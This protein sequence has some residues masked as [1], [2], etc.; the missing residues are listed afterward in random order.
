MPLK[1]SDEEKL[2]FEKNLTQ[3]NYNPKKYQSAVQTIKVDGKI[4]IK[5]EKI[6]REPKIPLSKR[7]N[8]Y[9]KRTISIGK[10]VDERNK[11]FQNIIN[12]QNEKQPESIE[13]PVSKKMRRKYKRQLH[14]R[15]TS[16]YIKTKDFIIC[17]TCLIEKPSSEFYPDD[18]PTGLEFSCKT[19][20]TN[21]DEILNGL[22]YDIPDTPDELEIISEKIYKDVLREKR[23]LN[24][25]LVASIRSR[26]KAALNGK[27]KA[28]KT[29]I[30]M[31][32][33]PEQLREHLE[34][35][36][37]LGMSWEN[38]GSYWHIDHIIPVAAFDM[39]NPDEQRACFHWSNLQPLLADVNIKK[40]D[41]LSDGKRARYLK[42]NL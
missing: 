26:I 32:C 23:H 15:K 3:L 39:N 16:Y 6:K 5:K 28:D 38:Y 35:K 20:S 36:F 29:L 24:K 34:S 9:K 4:K 13:E 11:K 25:R 14:N 41:I 2:Q 22:G 21:T 19:C 17:E 33:T 18:N 30:L 40:S 31:G 27:A 12:I 8:I 42:S 10:R 37:K 1:L 7:Q